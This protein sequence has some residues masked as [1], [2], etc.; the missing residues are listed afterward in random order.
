MKRKEGEV[1]LRIDL[2]KQRERRIRG[3]DGRRMKFGLSGGG[4]REREKKRDSPLHLT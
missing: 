4:E 1:T 2:V 3:K